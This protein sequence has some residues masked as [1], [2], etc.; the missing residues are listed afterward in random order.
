MFGTDYFPFLLGHEAAGIVE[1]LGP[2]VDNVRA[3]TSSW[4]GGRHVEALS[5]LQ[6]RATAPLCAASLN[7]Q[8]RVRTLDGITLTPILGI[9][10]FC[11][12][13]VVHSRQ[14]IPVDPYFPPS[15]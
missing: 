4:R 7:A 10:A 13:T 12:H 15:R 14:C 11:T 1:Q 6:D 5:I 2:G 8:P 3:T 9:G